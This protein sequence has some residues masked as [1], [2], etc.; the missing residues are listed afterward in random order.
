MVIV[1]LSGSMIAV[2][3]QT[4]HLRWMQQFDPV[5]KTSQGNSNLNMSSIFLPDPVSGSL[6]SMRQQES[7]DG[8]EKSYE[9]EKMPHSIPD[10]A[11]KS[12]FR[13]PEENIL[14]TGRKSDTWFMINSKTGECK[15]ILGEL[16][17]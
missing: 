5:L 16:R 7:D 9:L 8:E 3:P 4:S 6:Y 1:T 2:D 14:Y 10:L 15:N 13:S 11:L 17:I 12:P